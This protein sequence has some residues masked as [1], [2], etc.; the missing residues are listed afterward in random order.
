M[1][2]R[3]LLLLCVALLAARGVRPQSHPNL[4]D[5]S[6]APL[7][8]L[9]GTPS[10]APTGSARALI[11]LNRDGTLV[12]VVRRVP[13]P[14]TP[15]EALAALVTGPTDREQ[16]AGLASSVPP[17]W[18]LAPGSPFSGLV[19]VEIGAVSSTSSRNDEVLAFAQAV[20]TLTSLPDVKG[21]LFVRDG[22]ALPV[23]RADGSLSALPVARSDYASLL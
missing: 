8:G 3:V 5:P 18:K 17:P 14:A 22:K 21:V 19:R 12:A 20:L 7:G 10:P 6:T 9:L 16:Q 23:P 4:L 1:R 15:S 11:Y 13:S 2:R